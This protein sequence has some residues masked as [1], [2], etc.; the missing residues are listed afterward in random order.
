[1]KIEPLPGIS[2]EANLIKPYYNRIWDGKYDFFYIP[3]HKFTGKPAL[4][5][6][7]KVA[8]LS[9]RIFSEYFDKASVEQRMVFANVIDIFLPDPL[10]KYEHL[11]SFS[12]LFVTE[13]ASRRIVHL[14]SYVLEHWDLKTQIIKEPVALYDMNIS[15]R[16]DGKIP[17]NVYLAPGKKSLPFKIIDRYINITIPI[18]KGYSLLVLE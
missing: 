4:T 1:M 8:H 5:V 12:R 17:K 10:V 9:H 11:P 15:L 6:N 13:Q 18:S 2:A 7:R 16:I 3:P 14:L